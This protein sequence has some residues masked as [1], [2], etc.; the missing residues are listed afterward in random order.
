MGDRQHAAGGAAQ[1]AYDEASPWVEKLARAGYAAK[2]AVYLLVGGLAVAGALGQGGGTT[3]STGALA[4]ISGSTLGSAL[5]ALIAI[6]LV[7]YAL[8]GAVRAIANPENDGGF[9]RAYYAL[10]ALIH[11]SL[12]LEAA[13]LALGSGS[14]GGGSGSD[15]SHWSATLMQQPFGHWLLGIAGVGIA[16][17]G[18]GQIVNAWRVDLD[19]QLALGSMSSTGRTWTVRAGRFGLAAR[20]V[21]F[22]IIGAFAVIA[23]MQSQPSEARGLDGALETLGT[24]PWLLAIIAL[25]LA[26]Y[27]VYN[28]IRARYRVIRP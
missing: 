8:W 16:L 4:S 23:A 14:D 6:G 26:A 22:T 25:G 13:R 5:L 27:G 17:F 20:G 12:A 11:G 24:R 3:G 19:D 10:S 7:G 21:V 15:A 2:G 18:L 1:D 9:S 28:L